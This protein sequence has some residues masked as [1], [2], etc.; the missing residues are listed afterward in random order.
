MFF[1]DSWTTSHTI[2]SRKLDQKE[3]HMKE[4]NIPYLYKK[5]SNDEYAGLLEEGEQKYCS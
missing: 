2:S 4:A 3:T 1:L 5:K